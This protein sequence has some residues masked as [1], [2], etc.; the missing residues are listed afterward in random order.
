MG[1]SPSRLGELSDPD[2]GVTYVEERGQEGR[3]GR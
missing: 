1:G 3:L 2:A